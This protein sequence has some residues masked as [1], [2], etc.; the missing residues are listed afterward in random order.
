MLKVQHK[1]IK[2]IKSIINEDKTITMEDLL[3]IILKLYYTIIIYGRT[4]R[5]RTLQQRL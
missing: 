1:H 2:F 3:K 4:I 5:L